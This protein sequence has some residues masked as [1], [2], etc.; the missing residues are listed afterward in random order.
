MAKRNEGTSFRE[1]QESNEPSID[2]LLLADRAE[3]INGK[4]YTMGAAWDRLRVADFK[5][6]NMISIAV[7]ILVPWGACNR[8]HNLT[9]ELRDSDR[10]PLELR[11][12]GQFNTGRPPN[13]LPATTQKVVL[14]FPMIPVIVPR[15]GIYYFTASINGVEYKTTSFTAESGKPAMPAG[16]AP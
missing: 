2:F 8:Q 12:E 9:V 3:A 7:G 11:M 4:L 1:L 14:A 10:N 15:E 6:A 5:A 16:A 13:L